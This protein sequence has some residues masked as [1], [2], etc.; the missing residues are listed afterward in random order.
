MKAVIHDKFAEKDA[1]KI[2]RSLIHKSLVQEN[3][4]LR[5]GEKRFRLLD[6]VR[7]YAQ[8]QAE[9]TGHFEEVMQRFTRYYLS[10]GTKLSSLF[11]GPGEADAIKILDMEH[12]NFQIALQALYDLNEYAQ[13]LQLSNQLHWFWY[14]RGHFSTGKIW[15]AKF[16]DTNTATLSQEYVRGIA[17]HAW[18]LFVSGQWRRAH[19]QY[20][21]S[22]YHS[23]QI[24]D[25]ETETRALAGVGVTLRWMGDIHRGEEYTE[26]AVRVARSTDDPDLLI[27][28]LIW[29]YATTGGDFI[30]DPP[31]TQ[32]EEAA[33]LSRRR[34]DQWSYAHSLNGLGDL[35]SACGE[36]ARARI[37]YQLSLQIFQE[38]DDRWLIAW[39]EEGLG[40]TALRQNNYQ[41]AE[42]H[43]ERALALFLE[44][45]DKMNVAAVLVRM[46]DILL[47]LSRKKTAARMA[48]EASLIIDSLGTSDEGRSPRMEAARAR[49]HWYEQQWPLEWA[50]GRKMH[51]SRF[52]FEDRNAGFNFIDGT[53]Q[54]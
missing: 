13:G 26:Q 54:F 18:M 52:S 34:G 33:D 27:Y 28:T 43:T 7:Q 41:A 36:Y 29:A 35:L 48:G 14:R 32:L 3:G 17:S 31:Q 53:A 24:Q 19:S 9:S 25:R 21:E 45:G 22:L 12:A 20:A 16:L 51:P 49:C 42:K 47:K 46:A 5:S 23:R 8:Q 38:L 4:R 39:C 40:L 10:L 11:H 44:L 1:S 50:A 37:D 2:L 6:T 15:L 30:G